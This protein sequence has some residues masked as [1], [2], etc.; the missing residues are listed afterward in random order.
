M[1]IFKMRLFVSTTANHWN[2]QTRGE[3]QPTSTKST[4][5]VTIR[6]NGSVSLY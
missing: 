2:S 5:T 1:Y 4:V 6:V 3:G